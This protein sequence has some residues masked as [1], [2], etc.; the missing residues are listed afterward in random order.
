MN[1]SIP[2]PTYVTSLEEILWGICLV[3]VT[4]VIHAFGMVMTLRVNG[5]LQ[6]KV[7]Q[8]RSFIPDVGLLI[9]SSWMIILVHL[10]EVLVWALFIYWKQAIPN[11]NTSV[12]YYFSLNEYTTVGSNYTLVFKWRL[13]EGMLATAGLLAFAWSTGILLTLAQGFQDRQMQFL[14]DRH[15]R[16]HPHETSPATSRDQS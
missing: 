9:L 7:A 4:L 2:T 5:A 6:P 13:L 10:F 16:R 15:N 14:R 8:V 3:A 12:A 1:D 11:L